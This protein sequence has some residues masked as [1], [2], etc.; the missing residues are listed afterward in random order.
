MRAS[1]MAMEGEGSDDHDQCALSAIQVD[2]CTVME[3]EGSADHEMNVLS[4]RK[5]RS[6]KA[7]MAPCMRKAHKPHTTA[8]EKEGSVVHHH[9][10]S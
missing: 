4:V 10:L 3:E 7:V 6:E 1:R 5:I 2:K 8:M 9:L